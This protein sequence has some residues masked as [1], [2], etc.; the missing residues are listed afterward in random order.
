MYDLT[1]ERNSEQ[2]AKTTKEIVNWV[3][4]EYTKYTAEL[5]EAVDSLDITMPTEPADPPA[6]DALA[7][8][9]WK[10]D[11]KK[12]NDKA[13]AFNNFL[14]RLYSVVLGQCTEALEDRLKSTN[15][16]ANVQQ[17]GIELLKLV[18]TVCYNFEENRFPADALLDVKETFYRMAQGRNESLQHYYERFK[19]QL[20][21]MD[22]VGINITDDAMVEYYAAHNNR[23]GNATDEDRVAALNALL[24]T[25]FIR[26]ANKQYKPY[27]S[28]LRNSALNGNN[29]YPE[30]LTQAYNIMQR[31]SEHCVP[32]IE[33]GTDGIAFATVAGRNGRT[34]N[35][36][37][38][39]NCNKVGHYSDQ[40]PDDPNGEQG[41][42]FTSRVATDHKGKLPKSW[43][44]LD[45]EANVDLICNRKLVK[46]IRKVD[47]CLTVHCNAGNLTGYPS[48]SG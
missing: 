32:I 1:T 41:M 28:E 25:R 37:T 12:H 8:E 36:I 44:L 22:E 24:A 45:S 33:G 18:K 27:L 3:G 19:N 17:D 14:A 10:L 46:N 30:N 15:G 7:F 31:R 23:A 6:G 42:V 16:W 40:C 13:E 47:S 5:V 39:H 43:V 11:L 48:T 2:Y 20:A 34:Y 38:C 4:R 35:H 21:V 9:R 29:D 26:G